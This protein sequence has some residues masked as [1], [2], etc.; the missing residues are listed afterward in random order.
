MSFLPAAV[1]STVHPTVWDGAALLC[2]EGAFLAHDGL[3]GYSSP[4]GG[5]SISLCRSFS[6]QF[7]SLSVPLNDSTSILDYEALLI[8]C[9]LCRLAEGE[10]CACVLLING[11]VKLS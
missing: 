8:T 5:L 3:W 6:A 9:T 11:A 10:L 4:D 1:G 7:P 2:H